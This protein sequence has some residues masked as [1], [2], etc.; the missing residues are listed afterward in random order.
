MGPTYVFLHVL[1]KNYKIASI[2]ITTEVFYLFVVR[3]AK[4]TNSNFNLIEVADDF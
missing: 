3:F 4:F 2:L 1:L